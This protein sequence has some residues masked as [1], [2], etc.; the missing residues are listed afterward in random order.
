MLGTA[1]WTNANDGRFG[2]FRMERTEGG[3]GA[4]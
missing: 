3:A 2:T 4:A 1:N